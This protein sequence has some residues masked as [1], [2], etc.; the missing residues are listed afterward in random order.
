[1]DL[2][3]NFGPF[4]GILS[5]IS[6]LFLFAYTVYL[7][8]PQY[9]REQIAFECQHSPKACGKAEHVRVSDRI[10]NMQK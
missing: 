1:M 4:I 2:R 5:A 10:G 7:D 9:L 6:M 8:S 3:E